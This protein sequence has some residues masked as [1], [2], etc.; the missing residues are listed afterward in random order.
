MDAG[1]GSARDPRRGAARLL[2]GHDPVVGHVPDLRCPGEPADRAARAHRHGGRA[3]RVP[4]RAAVAVGRFGARRGGVG[5]RQRDRRHRARSGCAPV[6]RSALASRSA[7]GGRRRRRERLGRGGGPRAPSGPLPPAPR[8]VHGRSGRDRVRRRAPTR[9]AR[10]PARRLGRRRVRR[11]TGRRGARP[12][13]ERHRTGGRRRRSGA[14]QRLPG[15]P[16]R[17]PGRPARADALRPGPRRCGRVG[18]GPCDDSTRRADGSGRGRARPPVARR[19]GHRRPHGRRHDIGHARAAPVAGGVAAVGCAG[20][21]QRRESGP[22]HGTRAG[23]HV[24]C[25]RA[26]PRRPG[27]DRAA[28]APRCPGDPGRHRDA[29][30][31]RDH[32]RGR[33]GGAPR[34]GRPGSGALPRDRGRGG[35]HR[36]RCGQHVRPPDPLGAGRARGRGHPRVPDRPAGDRGRRTGRTRRPPGVDGAFG[37]SGR[38]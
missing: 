2:A 7:R 28:P 11:G 26:V 4:D 20:R 5:A 27:G 32:D 9:R 3:R 18:R 22:P 30:P 35:A 25:R 17:R 14:T 12:R 24:V 21:R 34:F 37:V 6:R 33:E 31:A 19:R 29:G 36:R 15:P 10:G 8:R 16:R 38:P 1:G 13:R 23:L